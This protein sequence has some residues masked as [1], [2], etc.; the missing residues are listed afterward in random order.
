MKRLAEEFPNPTPPLQHRSAFE[1]LLAVIL[2]AQCT[3]ARVN[4]T[5]PLLFPKDRP[6]T[7]D[8]ILNLGLEEVK[9]IIHPCG[10]YNSKGKALMG[11][12]VRV[13]E[14]GGVPDT[15]EELV[16]LP[17]VGG[18]TAQVI[19]SQW[20]KQA[21]FPVDTHVHRV[22]NRLGLTNSGKNVLKT[23]RQAKAVVPKEYWSDLH[24]LLIYHGRKT[25]TAY[26]PKCRSCPV[27]ELCHWPQ[28]EA[29]AA[30]EA[31]S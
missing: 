19:L 15:F 25:C 5:T 2:S 26:K 8:D 18:K 1:L 21:A 20:F 22:C 24:L 6:C 13:K 11:T 12:A 7:P 14:I 16:K 31:T 3:D 27:Y 28:K 23:E 10:F 29:R 17:G 4:L 9:R 30:E